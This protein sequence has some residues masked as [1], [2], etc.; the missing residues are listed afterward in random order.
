MRAQEKERDAQK[1]GKSRAVEGQSELQ[2]RGTGRRRTFPIGE[3]VNT[4]KHSKPNCTH[5]GGTD[6]HLSICRKTRERKVQT[7]LQAR[8]KDEEE[9][10]QQQGKL[11]E[12][13]EQAKLQGG[14]EQNER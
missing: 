9:H 13:S 11:Q 8:R 7:E 6:T 12:T 4:N 3:E 1:Q 5:E 2:A 14:L 10:T